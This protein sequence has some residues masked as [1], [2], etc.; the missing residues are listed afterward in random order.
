LDQFANALA[1]LHEVMAMDAGADLVLDAAIQRFE[2]TFEVAW[3]C[4]KAAAET[5]GVETVSPRDAIKQAF[6]AGWIDDE[7]LWLDLMRARNESSHICN[8]AIA[9]GIFER[10]KR[11][12]P[13]F[14]RALQ[15]MQKLLA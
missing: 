14:D 8:E 6:A 11:D 9:R 1:R 12:L 10:V 13:A 4:L 7:P 15:S 3:K 2:F 5:K